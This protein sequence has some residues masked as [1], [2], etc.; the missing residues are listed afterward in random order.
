MRQLEAEGEFGRFLWMTAVMSSGALVVV[1]LMYVT[2]PLID[3]FAEVYNTQQEKAAWAGS[4][5]ALGYAAGC[6]LVGVIGER[7]RKSRIL[8]I[9]LLILSLCTLL[10]GVSL[11][12]FWLIFSRFIQGVVAALF[13]ITALAY[14]A[15][16]IPPRF[17]PTALAFISCSF[18]LAGIFGQLYAQW[19]ENWL[20]WRMVFYL[21]SFLYI[22]FALITC[23]LPQSRKVRMHGHKTDLFRRFGALF[24]VPGLPIA[25]V[26]S[27]TVLLCFVA[28][29]S[30]LEFYIP[31]QFGAHPE[32]LM[33]LRIV[34]IPGILLSLAAGMLMR[35]WGAKALF[36]A[37]LGVSCIG[38]LIQM[39]TAAYLP[40]AVG[41]VITVAGL[42]LAN[43]SILVLVGMLSGRAQAAA[44]AVN[45]AAVFVGASAGPLMAAY[46][47]SYAQLCAVLIAVLFLAMLAAAFGIREERSKS[48]GALQALRVR[49]R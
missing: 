49:G 10:V 6:L 45:A 39:L 42:S 19:M 5:Y 23:L 41:S 33:R 46:I 7:Y 28:M 4:I 22:I 20:G 44:F 9:G 25:F 3:V 16:V 29:Y 32:G 18:F 8:V 13:P 31:E 38:L 47:A 11:S 30:G 24:R 40:I 35:W 34:G 14:T 2:I 37:G 43:P 36:I 15:D 48:A 26:L 12:L 21:L 27:S 1:S 17:R